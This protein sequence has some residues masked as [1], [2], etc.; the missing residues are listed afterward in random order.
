M[1]KNINGDSY[2]PKDLQ[3]LFKP[4]DIWTLPHLHDAVML[5]LTDLSAPEIF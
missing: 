1:N 4:S 5:K 3:L 2:L